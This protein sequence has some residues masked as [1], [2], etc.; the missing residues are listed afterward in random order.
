MSLNE[1]KFLWDDP[2]I[3]NDMW[4]DKLENK[5]VNSFVFPYGDID[6]VTK[7][8]YEDLYNLD[9]EKLYDFAERY[10]LKNIFIPFIYVY[11]KNNNYKADLGAYL[12]INNNLV[13]L[14]EVRKVNSL[15]GETFSEFVHRSRK[16]IS[17]VIV[18]YF[19]QNQIVNNVIVRLNAKYNDFASWLVIKKNINNI[20]EIIEFDI[21]SLTTNEAVI[22]IKIAINN[23]SDLFNIFNNSRL[24]INKNTYNEYDISII[25]EKEVIGDNNTDGINFDDE[26]TILVIE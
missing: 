6:D 21:I 3:W 22:D 7:L 2:N 25:S 8:S 16:N 10:N 26:Q 1:K 20:R 24:G 12:V 15:E 17:D 23:E 4:Q 9:L 18:N 13:N 19:E 5:Y 14:L 11:S